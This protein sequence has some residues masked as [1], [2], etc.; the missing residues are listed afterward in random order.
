V[1]GT[2]RVIRQ[3]HIPQTSYIRP[4]L[5][6]P[7]RPPAWGFRGAMGLNRTCTFP[8]DGSP[9]VFPAGGAPQPNPDW[10]FIPVAY[11][12]LARSRLGYSPNL[13]LHAA[14][15]TTFC[16]FRGYTNQCLDKKSRRLP[17]SRPPAPFICPV[18]QRPQGFPR[19][20]KRWRIGAQEI[21]KIHPFIFLRSKKRTKMYV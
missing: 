11:S 6:P 12:L 5:P 3:R 1:N 20:W 15:H 14:Y 19:S 10:P 16:K 21:P 8:G 4:A 9:A 2:Q 7:A 13:G 18:G 17:A